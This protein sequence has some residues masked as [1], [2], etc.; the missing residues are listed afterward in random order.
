MMRYLNERIQKVKFVEDK[1]KQRH[2]WVQKNLDALE[3]SNDE[4]TAQRHVKNCWDVWLNHPDEDISKIFTRGVKICFNENFVFMLHF[5]LNFIVL[6]IHNHYYF[7]LKNG[8][9]SSSFE[10][11]GKKDAVK[12][13]ERFN[14]VLACDPQ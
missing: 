2:D 1:L 10:I 3:Q 11:E 5:Y 13:I 6:Q 8:T 9:F 14:R 7:F 12:G 4:Q